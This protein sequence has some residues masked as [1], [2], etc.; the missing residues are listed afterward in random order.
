M[1][2]RICHLSWTNPAMPMC[3]VPGS[4]NTFRS[5][6]TV[7]GQSSRKAANAFACP[8]V[9]A[10]SAGLPVP[11]AEKM[12]SPRDPPASCVC[13]SMSVFLR[14]SPPYLNVCLSISRVIVPAT[15]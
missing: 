10:G 15:L 13:S 11:F 1:F 3:F 2:E 14:N 4:S 6:R 9:D 7:A 12:N 8:V 5:R